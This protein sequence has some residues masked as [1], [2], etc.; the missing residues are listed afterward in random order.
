MPN[1]II[2]F[3]LARLRGLRFPVL[4]AIA[5][6]LF[7]LTLLVP[8]PLPFADELLLGLLALLFASW[9][10]ERL[11]ADPREPPGPPQPPG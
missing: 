4:A 8:D 1:P 3:V 6:G 11:P 5:G 9:K 7:L 10:G 2:A